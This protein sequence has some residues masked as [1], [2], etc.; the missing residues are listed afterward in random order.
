[1]ARFAITAPSGSGFV[2]PDFRA[3]D[4]DYKALANQLI[5][6]VAANDVFQGVDVESGVQFGTTKIFL[7]SEVS[8][9]IEVRIAMVW[10][11]KQG[12]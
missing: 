8:R 1:V 10:Y 4:V 7:K 11:G 3:A 12:H 6:S 5:Q 2:I 9:A